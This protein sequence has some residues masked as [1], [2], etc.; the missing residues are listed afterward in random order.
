MIYSN[1]DTEKVMRSL[2]CIVSAVL[3]YGQGIY[4]RL[5]PEGPATSG[6]ALLLL[7]LWSCTTK[8]CLNVSTA[9]YMVRA[10]VSPWR[11]S[12]VRLRILE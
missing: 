5:D 8:D 3:V 6:L 10:G 1:N 2:K 12:A 7:S 4:L 11:K 9:T